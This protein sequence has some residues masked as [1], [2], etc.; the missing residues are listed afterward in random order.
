MAQSGAILREIGTTNRTRVSDYTAAAGPKTALI[1]RVHPSNFRVEGFTERPPLAALV[2]AGRAWASRSSRISAAATWL[3]R[4]R[5]SPRSAPRSPP[6]WI[7]CAS[8]ATSCS[9]GP[10]AGILAGRAALV[11]RLRK[12]PLMRAFRVDKLTYAALEATLP[13]YLA[14]RADRNGASAPDARAGRRDHRGPRPRPGRSP[15]RATAGAHASSA[16]VRPSAAAALRAWPCQPCC[17]RSNV[18]A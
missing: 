5:T 17:W 18:T 6:A 2:A 11:D 4:S 8:A 16:A 14:G 15:R 7:S 9:A 10:Q 13:E 3:R 12:H 1:L